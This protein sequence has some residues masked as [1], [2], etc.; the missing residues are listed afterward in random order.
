MPTKSSRAPLHHR[1]ASAGLLFRE[2]Q[3][4]SPAMVNSTRTLY[5]SAGSLIRK[6]D[7]NPRRDGKDISWICDPLGRI[8]RIDCS[9]MPDAAYTRGVQGRPEQ[10]RRTPGEPP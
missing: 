1:Q 10:Q 5:D 6:V 9:D 3:S 7:E 4:G 2:R 8:S